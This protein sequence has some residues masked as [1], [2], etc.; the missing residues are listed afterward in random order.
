MYFLEDYREKPI[1]GGFYKYELHRVTNPNV[2]L[3]E[4]VLR[5]K[6]NDIYVKWL[7]FD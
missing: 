4:K 1:A 5:K 3:I 7:G 6:E 2:Y